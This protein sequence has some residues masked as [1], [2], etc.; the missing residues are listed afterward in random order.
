MT[1]GS[2]LS[3]KDD[4]VNASY[5]VAF[6]DTV[7]AILAGVAI[8]T[9]VFSSGYDPQAGPGLVFH[10]LP[11][12]LSNLVGGYIFAFLF[13]FVALNRCS[14]IWNFNFRGKRCLFS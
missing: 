6:L 11:P 3:D 8:F 7:I 1:Y 2:Y 14:Y 5:L 10:V 9:V 4:I 12:L 13:F